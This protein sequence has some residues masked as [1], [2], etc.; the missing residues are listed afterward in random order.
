MLCDRQVQWC[1]KPLGDLSHKDVNTRLL[2]PGPF[3]WMGV[4]VTIAAALVL[5]EIIGLEV[6]LISTEAA[7]SCC[8]SGELDSS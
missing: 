6:L 2:R 7:G 3:R 4:P 1:R 5:I 8:G